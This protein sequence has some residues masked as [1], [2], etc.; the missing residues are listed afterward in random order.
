MKAKEIAVARSQPDPLDRAL[1]K[2]TRDFHAREIRLRYFPPPSLTQW[3]AAALIVH[4][5]VIDKIRADIPAGSLTL[6]NM[7]KFNDKPVATG[8]GNT[9]IEAVQNLQPAKWSL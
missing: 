8:K 6:Q 3:F 1:R 2:A 4:H 9:A 5:Q 7:D